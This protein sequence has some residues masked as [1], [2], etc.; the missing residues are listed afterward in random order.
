MLEK[1]KI[2][3]KEQQNDK[4]NPG[5]NNRHILSVGPSR[6]GGAINEFRDKMKEGPQ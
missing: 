3:T 6:P 1:E 4:V 2:M 5:L